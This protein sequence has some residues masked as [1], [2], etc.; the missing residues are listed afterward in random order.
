MQID[1]LEKPKKNNGPRYGRSYRHFNQ[2]EFNSEL[3]KV[4]WLTNMKNKNTNSC[5]EF[6]FQTIDHLLDEMAP[7]RKLTRKEVNLLERPWITNGILKSMKDRDEKYKEFVKEPDA[8]RKKEIHAFYKRKR[9]ITLALIRKSK[10]DYYA[11]FF[12]E[13]K[14]DTKKTWEG[15][16]RVI[17]ISKKSRIIP[18]QLRY[19]DKVHN[20][21]EAMAESFND[22]YVNIGNTVE[23]KIPQGKSHFTDY[24]TKRNTEMLLLKPVDED[25]VT[26]IVSSLKK[27][28][29]CGPASIPTSI[30]KNNIDILVAPLTHIINSSFIEGS[31]PDILKMAN[32]CP[33]YKKMRRISVRITG[34]FPYCLT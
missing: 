15:I 6:F 7:V 19:K 16:R 22:F 31:F 18:T 14:S 1:I 5:T 11:N 33:I 10:A 23:K 4:Q 30:L 3:Q 32:V 26:G 9:N 25:E 2:N 13:N 21:R 24:L 29:A 34:P 28:K 17:N 27:S 20:E 12:E 8:T